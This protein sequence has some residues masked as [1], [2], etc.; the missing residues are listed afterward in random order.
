[1]PMQLCLWTLKVE[2]HIIFMYHEIILFLDFFKPFKTFSRI[3]FLLH[4][5]YASLLAPNALG[6][7]YLFLAD[8]FCHRSQW[9][10]QTCFIYFMQPITLLPSSFLHIFH[11]ENKDHNICTFSAGYCS[12]KYTLTRG[13]LKHKLG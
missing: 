7:L 13:K 2:F 5:C 8:T 1:M 4:L 9:P 11:Q 10:F 3:V 6:N 12:A